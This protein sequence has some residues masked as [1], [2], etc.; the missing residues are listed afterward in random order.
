MLD[1]HSSFAYPRIA[2]ISE[3]ERRLVFPFS[4][5]LPLLFALPPVKAVFIRLH[6]WFKSCRFPVPPFTFM[7]HRKMGFAKWGQPFIVRYLQESAKP[8]IDS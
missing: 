8:K 5:A 7:R 2:P 1:C 3:D 4:L 6:P